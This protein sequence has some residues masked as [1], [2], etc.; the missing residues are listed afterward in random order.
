MWL[1]LVERYF[2]LI[3]SFRVVSSIQPGRGDTFF[4][5]NDKWNFNG[6]AQSLSLRYP[7]LY[8]YVLDVSVSTAEVYAHDDMAQ[9]F[10]LP[11]CVQ[12]YKEFK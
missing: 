12:A 11:P 10:L 8:S 5:W 7:R 9:L 6:S 1:L 3:N 2:K 4:F